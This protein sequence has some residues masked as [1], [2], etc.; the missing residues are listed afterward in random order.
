MNKL[1]EINEKY[2]IISSE[3]QHIDRSASLKLSI[4]ILRKY[5]EHKKTKRHNE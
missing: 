5:V 2:T 4:E 3:I 1:K